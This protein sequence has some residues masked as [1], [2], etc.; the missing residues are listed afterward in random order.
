VSCEELEQLIIATQR[1]LCHVSWTSGYRL[2]PV[3]TLLRHA[4]GHW[5]PLLF[6]VPL[7]GA[8]CFFTVS[9][10]LP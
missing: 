3:K 5:D 2:T 1:R 9:H 6:F 4:R 8:S 10:R 7:V